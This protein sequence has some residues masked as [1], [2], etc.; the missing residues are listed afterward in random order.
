[1]K[2]ER[3]V[4]LLTF[5]TFI[6]ILYLLGKPRNR[7]PPRHRIRISPG[8]NRTQFVIGKYVEAFDKIQRNECNATQLEDISLCLNQM[9]QI[10][11][12]LDKELS[13]INKC[14]WCQMERNKIKTFYHHTFFGHGVEINKTNIKRIIYLHVTSFLATQ[15]LCC[16]KLIVWVLHN[17]QPELKREIEASFFEYIE[18]GNLEM[19]LFSI[20]ELCSINKT[21]KS[22]YSSFAGHSTCEADS[23]MVHK[24]QVALSDLVRFGKLNTTQRFIYIKAKY[25]NLVVLD[26]YGGIY[27]D[28]DTFYLHDMRLL[29]NKNFVYRWSA[30]PYV[31]TAVMSLNKYLNKDVETFMSR[32][33]KS[34]F[35]FQSLVMMLYPIQVSRRFAS[36]INQESYKLHSP[37]MHTYTS[38]LFDP[39]WLCSDGR[40]RPTLADSVCN[41][42]QFFEPNVSIAS[43]N[44]QQLI[45]KFFPGAYTYHLHYHNKFIGSRSYFELFEN[46]YRSKILLG[47][48]IKPNSS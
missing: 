19:K 14:H 15:N 39:A 6:S 13:G 38:F 7:S 47:Q 23:T 34:A 16:T 45:D 37:F 10:H 24:N 11:N 27:L 20:K 35:S 43:N 8:L 32:L 4:K 22:L 1:M 5:A 46:H 18:K 42:N 26:I 48:N 25:Y 28:G 31:N 36:Y 30:Q 17:F 9:S 2:S 12:D 41:F 29:W 3:L 44:S 40:R 33:A 21:S